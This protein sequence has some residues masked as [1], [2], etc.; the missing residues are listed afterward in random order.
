MCT[1][2][3]VQRP[4]EDGSILLCNSLP[5]ACQT[6]SLTEPQWERLVT[7]KSLKSYCLNSPYNSAPGLQ[8]HSWL[9]YMDAGIWTPVLTPLYQIFSPN[10]PLPQPQKHFKQV[11]HNPTIQKQER[12]APWGFLSHFPTV[13]C[14]SITIRNL[15]VY[16]KYCLIPKAL[17]PW[18]SSCAISNSLGQL[19]EI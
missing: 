2:V 17:Q 10:E 4:E 13:T 15:T 7:S 11:I 1:H 6:G 3:Y 5:C 8:N 14:L 19:T 12:L 16:D 9:F 18:L